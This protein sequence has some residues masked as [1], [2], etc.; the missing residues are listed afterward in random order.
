MTSIKDLWNKATSWVTVAANGVIS[1]NITPIVTTVTNSV[2]TAVHSVEDTIKK[3]EF[4]P[5]A[6]KSIEISKT[7]GNSIVEKKKARKSKKKK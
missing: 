6:D 5:S 2:S 4:T 1:A 7:D 3:I